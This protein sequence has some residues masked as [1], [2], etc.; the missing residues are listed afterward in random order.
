[1][2]PADFG[3][4]RRTHPPERKEALMPR[5]YGYFALAILLSICCLT[6]GCSESGATDSSSS[7]QAA[8]DDGGDV[9]PSASSAVEIAPQPSITTTFS[10][11]P[12]AIASLSEATIANNNAQ[13]RATTDWLVAQGSAAVA[14]LAE[15]VGDGN[16]DIKV[17]VAACRV[18]GKVGAPAREALIAAAGS[19]N[20]YVRLKAISGLGG[21]RPVEDETVQFL[22]VQLDSDNEQTLREALRALGNLGAPAAASVER[23]QQIYNDTSYSDSVRGQANDALK[24]IDPRR[25][26][27]SFGTS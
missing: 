11:V 3:G 19:E 20:D 6:S 21:L 27:Q 8:A 7:P 17:R 16:V 10:S 4:L 13:A 18:L 15:V 14:P 9:A 23:V 5:T 26:L 12:A 22:I 24:K 25:G 1:M 2:H